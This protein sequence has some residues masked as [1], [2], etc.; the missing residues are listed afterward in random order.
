MATT[1]TAATGE[2]KREIFHLARECERLLLSYADLGLKTSETRE[3]VASLLKRFNAWSS[4]LGVFAAPSASLDKT[5]QY[6]DEI[7]SFV[8]QLLSLLR[9][10]LEFSTS[11]KGF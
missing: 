2:N 9:R 5:L 10:N 4:N 8:T 11:P 6:S 3:K 1:S 7:R